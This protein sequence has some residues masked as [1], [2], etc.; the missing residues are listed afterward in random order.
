[1][2][3]SAR[4]LGAV[5]TPLTAEDVVRILHIGVDEPTL[6]LNHN[7]HSLYYFHRSASFRKLYAAAS[8]VVV[9][10]WPVLKLLNRG[11]KPAYSAHYR[12]G[13]TDWLQRLTETGSETEFRVFVVGGTPETLAAACSALEAGA[14]H[15]TA[16]GHHGYFDPQ[17][18]ADGVLQ[19]MVAARPHLVL[20]G[21]GMPRQEDFILANLDKL[22]PAYVA[23]VGGAVDY[24]AGHQRLSP[25]IFGRLGLEWL[26]RLLHD[27]GRLWRRYLLEP[28]AL[29]ALVMRNRT[30]KKGP[31]EREPHISADR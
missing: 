30:M 18:E 5:V 28:F 15:I 23:S 19:A 26:W 2:V 25:R 31:W 20:V 29:A 3:E 16:S 6:L 4:V 1:M 9:D 11:H 24:L 10:G 17:G 22:P 7:L 12:V 13:S 8:Y 14:A 21:M 27:P